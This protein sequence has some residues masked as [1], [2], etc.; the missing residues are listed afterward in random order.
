M[1]EALVELKEI[2]RTFLQGNVKIEAL[3]SATCVVLP[4]D[5]IAVIGASGSGKSTLLHIMGNL[6]SQTSG[7]IAWPLLNKDI[8]LRPSQI[9]FVF[10]MQSLLPTLSILENIELPLLLVD[11]TADSAEKVALD[12]LERIELAD[13]KDKLPDELSGGQLQRVTVARAL[14]AKPKLILADEPTGQLDHPTA[15]HLMDI[16]LDYID[17]SDTALV[18][19]THDM[20]VAERMKTHWFMSHGLLGVKSR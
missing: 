15:K 4:K 20:A 11:H 7:E 5:R 16:L 18:I 13:L 3:K 12:V 17:D 6:D 10:Q 1:P 14:A 9:G 8:S 2:G 19:S